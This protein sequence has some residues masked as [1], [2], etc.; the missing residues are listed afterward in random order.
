MYQKVTFYDNAGLG[1]SVECQFRS[2][3]ALERFVNKWENCGE[4]L[5][6]NYD[7]WEE[8]K[9]K[10]PELSL[11]VNNEICFDNLMSKLYEN[12]DLKIKEYL[13]SQKH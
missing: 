5:N 13:A 3:L 11:M 9:N 12:Q 4:A 8:N 2:E 1:N 6:F 10:Y 7:V